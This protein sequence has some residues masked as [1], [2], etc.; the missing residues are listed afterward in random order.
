[1]HYVYILFSTKDRQLYIGYAKDLKKRVEKHQ[2]GFVRSTKH[3]LPIELI[4]YESYLFQADAKRRE[5]FLKGGNGRAQLKIQLSDCL[6]KK[7]Y[8][9]LPA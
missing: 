4:Y 8:K 9:H 7:R 5:K 6:R 3:R 2:N 1:M